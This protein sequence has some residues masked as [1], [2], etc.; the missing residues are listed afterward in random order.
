MRKWLAGFLSIVFLSGCSSVPFQKTAYVPLNEDDPSIIIERFK[1]NLPGR[2]QLINTIVF[3]YNWNTF[4]GIGY[5]DINTREEKFTVVCINPIGIKLFEISG[6][7]DG[8]VQHFVLDKFAGEGDFVN[9]VGEDIKRI[10]FDLVPSLKAEIKKKKFQVMTRQPW[11][12][13]IVEYI[14]AGADGYLVEKNY[15]EKD[16]LN[17][18][19]SYYE[20]RQKDGKIY[21]RG[22]ILK[23]YKY[24]YSLTVRLKEIVD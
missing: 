18:R 15:Y 6:D 12:S 17:W 7:K 20:Y 2:F 24:R 3:M 16:I 13:G 5:I 21:P 4:S 10:Y 9:A 11:G 1:D 19:V 8:V 23:N 14:F 22:I